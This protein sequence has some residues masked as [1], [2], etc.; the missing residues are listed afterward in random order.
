MGIYFDKGTG[1][2]ES[3][4]GID[5]APDVNV[6]SSDIIQP[7]DHQ[8]TLIN[9]AVTHTGVVVAPSGTNAQS[10]WQVVPEG[11]TDFICNLTMD[12]GVGTVITNVTWSEDGSAISGKT[13]PTL[14]SS[15]FAQKTSAQWYPVGG[16]FYKVSVYNGDASPRTCS[17]NI[18]FRP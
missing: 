17:A 10:T 5:G 2:N 14:P 16:A 9:T 11:M 8:A 6:K 1:R 3:Q 18:K 15:A 4:T 7:V 12:S 13:E